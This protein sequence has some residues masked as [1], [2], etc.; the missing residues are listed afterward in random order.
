MGESAEGLWAGFTELA[1][2]SLT[3]LDH[4]Q[5]IMMDPNEQ[6]HDMVLL[7]LKALWSHASPMRRRV[8]NARMLLLCGI[9]ATEIHGSFAKSVANSVAKSVAK[10]YYFDES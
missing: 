5:P 2:A 10:A 3:L 8:S 9:A 4:Q 1:D 6:L 7:F